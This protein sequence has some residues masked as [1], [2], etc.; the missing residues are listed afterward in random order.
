MSETKDPFQVNR[1]DC[2][3]SDIATSASV[4]TRLP[5]KAHWVDPARLATSAWA[6]PLIGALIG[7]VAGCF[8]TIFLWL[9]ISSGVSAG[10]AIG[11]MILITGGLHE[12]GIA[13]CA[14]GLGGGTNKVHALEIMKDSRLGAYGALILMLFLIIRWTALNDLSVL[15]PIAVLGVVGAVSRLPM[16]LVMTGMDNAR[17]DGFSK[18]VGRPQTTQAMVAVGLTLL[19]SIIFLGFLG[20]LFLPLVVLSCLPIVYIASKK[21]GGQ[22]GDVLGGIQQCAEVAALGLLTAFLI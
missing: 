20:L 17:D 18:H 2:K 4:L 15:Q 16:V 6:Y 8:L 7:L 9:G 13:D 19:I 1:L 5:M 14:D 11:V 21:I 10:C 22:T 3:L 12:D